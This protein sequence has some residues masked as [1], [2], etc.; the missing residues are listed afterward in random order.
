MFG[1][2]Y[3]KPASLTNYKIIISNQEDSS[4]NGVY[5][6][7]SIENYEYNGFNWDEDAEYKSKYQGAYYK[8]SNGNHELIISSFCEYAMEVSPYSIYFDDREI[9]NN[10]IFEI[11]NW[12]FHPISE[13]YET[14]QNP[15]YP[16][17]S[18]YP[19]I[20]ISTIQIGLYDLVVMG[21]TE[22]DNPNFRVEHI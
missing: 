6:P 12:T 2:V 8:Y 18:E 17:S 15:N 5:L 16:E 13:T 22:Y 11:E 3:V 19:E 4:Y 7:V 20:Y 9:E 1:L 10:L 14:I 21:L